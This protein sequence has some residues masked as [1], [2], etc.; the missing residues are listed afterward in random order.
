MKVTL[1]AYKYP[2]FVGGGETH[3]QNL[4]EGLVSRGCEVTVLTSKPEH[5]MDT[6]SYRSG[7]VVVKYLDG[8]LE[9]CEDFAN[10]KIVPELFKALQEEC[11]II[12]V[13]NY[14]PAILISLI[15]EAI[16]SKLCVSLFETRIL[17]ERV[18]DLWGDYELENTIQ[19]TLYNNIS[20]DLMIAGS[21]AY[22]IWATDANFPSN[23]IKVIPFGTDIQKFKKDDLIRKTCRLTRGIK[24]EFVFFVPARLVPRKKIEDVIVATGLIVKQNPN[25]KIMLTK[26]ERTSNTDY[27]DYINRLIS[28][29]NL[30]NNIIWEE[31]VRWNEM[32]KLYSIADA[33]VL[34]S[35]NEGFGI[36][37]IEAMAAEKPV[38]T[39]NIEGHDEI[40]SHKFNG[41]LYPPGGIT[42]LKNCMV[43]LLEGNYLNLVKNGLEKVLRE[44]DS[45]QMIEKHY[46][47][48][49]EL[50]T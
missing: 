47:A 37:L 32:P 11:D 1:I 5:D 48:Y 29:N 26:P 12:H 41:L 24:D 7:G 8:F 21:E 45:E 43:E 15:R 2:P 39:T 27:I 33:V 9:S 38:I 4:A 49:K 20:A 28:K 16:K 30:K 36:A 50:L 44:Y 18:F 17:G 46:Y 3:L 31:N 23:L 35:V 34:P 42:E 6:S 25:V 13:F 22:K 40:I 14:V 19:K 10:K